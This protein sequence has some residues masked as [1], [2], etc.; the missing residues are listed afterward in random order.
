MGWYW[1]KNSSSLFDFS[2]MVSRKDIISL[3]GSLHS[4]F[5]WLGSPV[6]GWRLA[7]LP[8]CGCSDDLPG[9]GFAAMGGDEYIAEVL[10]PWVFAKTGQ[11]W[12]LL[13]ASKLWR[14]FVYFRRR[15]KSFEIYESELQCRCLPQ[16]CPYQ[17]RTKWCIKCKCVFCSQDA[18]NAEGG[19][20]QFHFKAL[21]AAG[22]A[23]M[24]LTGWRV[25]FDE[26]RCKCGRILH[27]CCFLRRAEKPK[28][29][30]V[31]HWF[32]E[33]KSRSFGMTHQYLL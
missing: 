2:G 27:L 10:C 9:R 25:Q 23:A 3:M 13:Q 11:K 7:G 6:G 31:K 8:L 15:W 14:L 21:G 17:T 20:F 29:S 5:P 16:V 12:A 32:S 18:A 30:R 22:L 24:P 1:K 33:K 19:H 4:M 28:Q 26:C